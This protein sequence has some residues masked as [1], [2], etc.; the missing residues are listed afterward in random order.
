MYNYRSF[1]FKLSLNNPAT[2]KAE[3]ISEQSFSIDA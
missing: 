2:G 1:R 3:V